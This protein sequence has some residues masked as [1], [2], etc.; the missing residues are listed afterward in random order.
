MSFLARAQQKTTHLNV[1]LHYICYRLQLPEAYFN[2]A[3]DKYGEVGGW[4]TKN[5]SPVL[6]HRPRVFHQGSML[7]ET[8]VKPL[9]QVEYDLDVIC[10]LRSATDRMSPREVYDLVWK[11]LSANPEYKGRL[12]PKDRCIRVNF[13]N[14]FHLDVVPAI[15]DGSESP[16][17]LSIPDLPT[18][19][20]RWKPSDPEGF[21]AWFEE[22]CKK[23][24]FQ[25]S[26]EARA[27]VD[28]I[29]DPQPYNQKF[30][31]KRAV[32]LIKRWRDKRFHG[33]EELSTP[34]IV[35]TRL[36]GDVYDGEQ[37][38]MEAVG[39]I[40]DRWHFRFAQGR[41]LVFNP[42][43]KKE[44][45]SE[46]WESKPESFE[47]F[48]LAVANF[49]ERWKALPGLEGIH[50]ITK[51]LIELFGDVAADAV[52]ESFEQME[53]ARKESTRHVTRDT[54]TLLTAPLAGAIRVK[55]HTFHGN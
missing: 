24:V 13:P 38:L 19:A 51:E 31:L 14:K 8:T 23:M 37:T 10:L 42:V 16:T 1:A 36:A 3:R 35:V 49:R 52:K 47:A 33:N 9:G 6:V 12:K 40:L 7:L 54:V 25:F 48:K 28:P 18:N 2:T 21:A 44:L 43:N 32:Q 15:M 17:S 4:L 30:P 29:P 50:N 27:S 20:G 53:A 11:R 41:P 55:S 22:M 5:E 34:S 46:K 39:K 45:I 26:M